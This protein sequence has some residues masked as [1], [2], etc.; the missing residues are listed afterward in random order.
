MGPLVTIVGP[1]V[2]IIV[3]PLVQTIVG[4]L[5]QTIVGPLVRSGTHYRG[6]ICDEFIKLVVEMVLVNAL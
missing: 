5:V 3:G 2:Q 6:T 4:R 1:T